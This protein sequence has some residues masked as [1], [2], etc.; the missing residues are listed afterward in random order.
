M[1]NC[2]DRLARFMPRSASSRIGVR[3][4]T[5]SP[6]EVSSPF[7]ICTAKGSTRPGD[8]LDKEKINMKL[9]NLIHILMGMLCI[10]LLPRVQAV[11]P[12]PDGGY[13]NFTTAEG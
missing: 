2:F 10:G 1:A 7:Q 3:V 12:P 9:R 11:V 5:F 6:G 4:G 8:K 13:P